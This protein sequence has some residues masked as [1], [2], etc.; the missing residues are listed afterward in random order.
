MLKKADEIASDIYRLI[1][2]NCED[3]ASTMKFG[4]DPLSLV[5]KSI[6]VSKKT[7]KEKAG[8]KRLTRALVENVASKLNEYGLP[9]KVVDGSKIQVTPS[10]E[11]DII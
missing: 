10:P 5:N 3:E 1:E 6:E 4:S 11:I 9:S 7:I 2:K 8:R